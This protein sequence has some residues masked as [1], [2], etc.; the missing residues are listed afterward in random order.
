MTHNIILNLGSEATEKLTYLLNDTFDVMNGRRRSESINHTNWST[1]TS[2]DGRKIKGKKE[3]LETMV[4]MIDITIECDKE[5]KGT[6]KLATFSSKTTLE[7]WRLSLL[8]TID[9]TEELLNP[10]NPEEMYD[11]VL[12]AKWNQDALEVKQNIR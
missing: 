12:T 3:I 11:F 1:R 10:S 8:S 7:G 6:T 4:R 2:E 9:L 5:K